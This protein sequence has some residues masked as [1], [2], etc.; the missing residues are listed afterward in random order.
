MMGDNRDNSLDSRVAVADGGVGYV[1]VENLVAKAQ[2]VVG[3]YDYLGVGSLVDI[4]TKIRA[5]RFLTSID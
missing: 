1:P 5:S 3:S 4:V 2:I